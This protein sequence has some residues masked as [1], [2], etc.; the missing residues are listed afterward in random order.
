[1]PQVGQVQRRAQI[2]CPEPFVGSAETGRHGG[3]VA[4]GRGGAIQL[5]ELTSST[6]L[7]SGGSK[8]KGLLVGQ[9]TSR[10][11]AAWRRDMRTA[12]S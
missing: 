1:M 4:V 8:A 7:C 5:L 10:C 3:I 11:D 12:A 6:T 9:P 2:K